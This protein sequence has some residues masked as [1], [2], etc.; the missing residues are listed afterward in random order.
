M[1]SLPPPPRLRLPREEELALEEEVQATARSRIGIITE[2]LRLRRAVL[3]ALGVEAVGTDPGEIAEAV[4]KAIEVGQVRLK[5][6]KK[7]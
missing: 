7:R 1:S 6:V 2:A 3:V 4:R 5:S